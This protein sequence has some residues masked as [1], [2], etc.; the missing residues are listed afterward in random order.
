MSGRTGDIHITAVEASYFVSWLAMLFYSLACYTLLSRPHMVPVLNIF[1][2]V[3]VHDSWTH[4]W[5]YQVSI[6]QENTQ[7]QN[8]HGEHEMKAKLSMMSWA[9]IRR[10]KRI[11]EC[12]SGHNRV[13]SGG[14]R[15]VQKSC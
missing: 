11:E 8:I 2:L 10:K 13:I 7:N 4:N 9:C 1:V 3:S 14:K 6:F 15:F 12:I 5:L